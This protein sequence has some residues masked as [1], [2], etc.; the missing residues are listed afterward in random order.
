M[1]KGA[2]AFSCTTTVASALKLAPA[3]EH[4]EGLVLLTWRHEIAAI[5]T[6]IFEQEPMHSV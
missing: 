6:V 1:Q 4:H 5:A 3:D 2:E